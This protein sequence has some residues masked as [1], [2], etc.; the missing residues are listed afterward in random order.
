M[1]AFRTGEGG[2]EER[3]MGS[4]ICWVAGLLNH[5]IDGLQN[6]GRGGSGLRADGEVGRGWIGIGMFRG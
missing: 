2:E 4:R 3:T 6:F 5:E 1:V